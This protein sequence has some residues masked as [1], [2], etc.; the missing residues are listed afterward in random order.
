MMISGRA[1]AILAALLIATPLAAQLLP[2]D[3][4]KD[5]FTAGVPIR[6]D[7][8]GD[9]VSGRAGPDV[10]G[11]GAQ[12]ADD[13]P[14]TDFIPDAPL[15]PFAEFLNDPVD[16]DTSWRDDFFGDP[17]SLPPLD[18]GLGDAVT[19]GP[20]VVTGG[21]PYPAAPTQ[22]L[23]TALP[24]GWV[25]HDVEVTSNRPRAVQPLR[26]G[27]PADLTPLD[28]D[29]MLSFHGPGSIGFSDVDLQAMVRAY[30]ERRGELHGRAL[31]LS[32]EAQPE[33]P[34]IEND[35]DFTVTAREQVS[36]ANGMAMDWVS[37]IMDDD[38]LAI[39]Y[40]VFESL[41]PLPGNVWLSVMVM[42]FDTGLDMRQT[43]ATIIQSLRFDAAPA[44]SAAA[45]PVS[46]P[47]PAP[48]QPS[49]TGPSP[50][51]DAK[52]ESAAQPQPMLPQAVPPATQARP[53]GAV[54]PGAAGADALQAEIRFWEGVRDSRDATALMGYL[55]H[56]PEGH[57]AP[58][59]RL[60]LAGPV[61][62]SVPAA[63]P[64]IGSAA[65]PTGPADPDAVADCRRLT[66]D[67]TI[68]DPGGAVTACRAAMVQRPDDADL[69]AALARALRAS[70]A[71]T[72]ALVQYRHAAERGHVSSMLMLALAYRQ[73]DGVAQDDAEA[74]NWYRRAAAGGDA[75]SMS[76][77]GFM[78]A[79]GL[80]GLPV[81][82]REAARLYLQAAEA[83]NPQGMYNI[84][85]RYR[86]G[87][88]IPADP[89]RALHWLRRS[90]EAG[91]L[92][93]MSFL[94]SMYLRGE[95]VTR[96]PQEAFVW[97]NRA[98]DQGYARAMAN[99]GLAHAHGH[100]MPVDPE[101]GA[102][103]LDRAIRAGAGEV[104]IGV[105]DGL[106]RPTVA[107]LQRRMTGAGVY[108]GGIDGI[109]GPQTR[110]AIRDLEVLGP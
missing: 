76:N 1:S 24:E 109:G 93:A 104:V 37:G 33:L 66:S 59:A 89:V 36:L 103:W 8:G 49:A 53:S 13:R 101:L 58:L 60:R 69:S 7:P 87:N 68:G 32:L 14:L 78:H 50:A 70:G 39:R 34:G 22:P 90:A 100:G 71:Q 40:E 26:V 92:S 42:S 82:Q 31:I 25:W 29:A 6:P 88:G 16:E 83:G 77:L 102:A 61:P 85:E 12:P 41:S 91:N 21:A 10:P 75:Q 15:R 46:P 20:A 98:A 56:W 18:N 35:A 108:R 81:D 47:G 80:G 9:G 63:L 54:P 64:P 44:P 45:E 106:P 79:R 4:V 73:G 99:I 86:T 19:A 55:Q 67:A 17:G 30:M 95:R 94:G 72:E 48:A 27:L 2:G 110:A 65:Q 11:T 74:V 3:S 97:L 96:D 52:P 84:S 105:M 5:D 38:Y 62:G 28:P 23:G 107:A 51:P 57:F 43:A